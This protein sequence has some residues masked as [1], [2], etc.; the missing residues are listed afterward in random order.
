LNKLYGGNEVN[1][2]KCKACEWVGDFG[3]TIAQKF[4]GNFLG[5][6]EIEYTCPECGSD[7][8]EQIS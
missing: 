8:F 5:D 4:D 7:E 6:E 2:V 3:S 1:T